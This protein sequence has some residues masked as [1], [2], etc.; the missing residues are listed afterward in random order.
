MAEKKIRIGDMLVQEGAI[1]S[2]QLEQAL[3]EQKRTGQ[4]LGAAIV[5]LGF[6]EEDRL[7]Q[8]LSEQLQ[9]PFI[10]LKTYNFRSDIVQRLPEAMARRFRALVLADE[11]DGL[12]IGMADPLDLFALDASSD[13]R[14]VKKLS[15]S[16]TRPRSSTAET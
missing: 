13:D 11:P 5:S 4:K 15:P 9:I 10:Q 6:L 1:S 8:L 3:A 16:S 7:L 2:G 14:S 12:L